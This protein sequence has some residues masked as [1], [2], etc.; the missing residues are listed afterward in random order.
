MNSSIIKSIFKKSRCYYSAKE[1]I[2][3][4][5][6]NTFLF[7]TLEHSII[8]LTKNIRH[9]VP[10]LNGLN[11]NI[12]PGQFAALVGPSGCG[13]ST[14]I[15]LI[16]RFYDVISGTIQIDGLRTYNGI[17]QIDN[18]KNFDSILTILFH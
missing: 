10:V 2:N 5:I 8:R 14:T 1:L 7:L 15:G 12:K 11:L 6:L 13:K 17:D 18:S 9:N 3:H 16:E 4:I